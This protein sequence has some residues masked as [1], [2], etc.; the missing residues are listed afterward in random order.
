MRPKRSFEFSHAISRSP[1]ASVTGGI[2]IDQSTADPDAALFKFQHE[3]YVH[4]V[5]EAG[6]DLTLLEPLEAFP[7]SVFVEDPVL[8]VDGAAIVLRPGAASRFGEAAAMRPVLES[9]F[10][11]VIDLPGSG[12]VDGGDV[13]LTEDEALIGSSERTDASGI[14]ALA[15]ILGDFG[16]ATRP[17]DTP[18]GVLHFKSDCGLLD[19]RTVFA[20]RR[21]AA[22]GCFEGYEVLHAPDGE[23]AAANLIRIND[24]IFINEGFAQ[25]RAMLTEVGYNV[26]ALDTSEAA[27]VDGGLSCM[28]LRFSLTR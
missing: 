8:V 5:R 6:V 9:I 15:E 28:T 26:V 4:A 10:P 1:S 22:S 21:L 25:T 13:L 20:T 18:A 12:Y 23:E 27:K 14:D 11:S 17:V 7:D 19:E 3:Q 2:R 24:T 16:Y